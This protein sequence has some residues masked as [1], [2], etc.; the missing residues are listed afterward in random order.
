MLYFWSTPT[1]VNV[2]AFNYADS[3]I[4]IK[5]CAKAAYFL[6]EWIARAVDIFGPDFQYTLDLR[7]ALARALHE[8]P[9]ASQDALIEALAILEELEPKMRKIYGNSHPHTRENREY[10]EGARMRREDIDAGIY[11]LD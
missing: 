2:A 1:A 6:R 5:K 11:S 7:H 10:L 9:R 4:S 3:L 8:D